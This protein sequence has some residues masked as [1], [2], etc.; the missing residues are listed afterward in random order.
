MYI[1]KRSDK[2]IDAV[3]NQA[4]EQIEEGSKWPGMSYEQG[5]EAG[6]KWVLGETDDNPMEG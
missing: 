1:K 4:A 5:V 2:E 3:L 6:V